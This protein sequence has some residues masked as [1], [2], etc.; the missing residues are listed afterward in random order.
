MKMKFYMSKNERDELSSCVSLIND[1]R[2][3]DFCKSL[4][5]MFDASFEKKMKA[6]YE[7]GRELGYD[8]KYSNDKKEF[9]IIDLPE[10]V[11]KYLDVNSETLT[12][13]PF[14]IEEQIELRRKALS[15]D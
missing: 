7:R 6:F 2:V 1:A 15:V 10:F 5:E 11:C 12:H 4:V 14:F 3:A 13:V 9:F 8:D